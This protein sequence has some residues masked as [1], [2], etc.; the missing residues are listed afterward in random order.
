MQDKRF[1]MREQE[2]LDPGQIA[3][4]Q[5]QKVKLPPLFFESI[6]ESERGE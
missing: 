3:R 4:Q 6:D 2:I 5:L 1:P